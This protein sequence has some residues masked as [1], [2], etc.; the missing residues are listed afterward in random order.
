MYNKLRGKIVEVFGSQSVYAEALG[1][2]K[3]SLSK[4]LNCKTEF[5]QTDIR[6]WCQ[7]LE[8]PLEEA[9]T[10]FFE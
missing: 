1:I 2:S 4:K 5:N 3:N 6:K 7:L 8:I 10:Y 9:G